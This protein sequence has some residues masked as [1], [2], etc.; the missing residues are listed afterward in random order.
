[1][2][3]RSD[4][5][6]LFVM[7]IAILLMSG[8]ALAQEA[9]PRLLIRSDDMGFSHGSNVAN[10]QLLESGLVFNISV[11]FAAPWYKEAVEI[12]K[13]YPDVSVGVHLCANSEW[14]NYKWGPVAGRDQVPSLVNE[15]GLFFGSYNE[16]NVEHTPSVEDLETEFRAQ[17]ERALASGLTIDYVD[18][19]MGA[20]MHT[21]EQRA[22]VERLAQEYNLAISG[23]YGEQSPGRFSDVPLGEQP[24][25]LTTLVDSLAADS[26][27]RL[28]F[29]VGTDTPEL[30]AMQDLNEGGVPNMSEQRQLEMEMLLSPEFQAALTRNGVRLVTYRDLIREHGP[31]NQPDE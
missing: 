9:P 2:K 25:R 1:M 21:P 17:I 27:Y 28:V 11:L 30:Q 10:R 6:L 8:L 24:A 12:L 29:H 16:L 18:S 15:D 31:A 13:E 7:L 20:G 19:H 5:S 23:Y 3:L 26:L 4:F 14:K 22:M